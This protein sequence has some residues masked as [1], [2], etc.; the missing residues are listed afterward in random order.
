MLR[1]ALLVLAIAAPSQ[2]AVRGLAVD[3]SGSKVLVA[4]EDRL[5]LWDVA[6]A[7]AARSWALAAH[8]MARSFSGQAAWTRDGRRVVFVGVAPHKEGEDAF[9][10]VEVVDAVTGKIE[11]RVTLPWAP[12]LGRILDVSRDGR[13]AAV[14][15]DFSGDFLLIVDLD[16]G[17]VRSLRGHGYGAYAAD[18]SDDGRL[19][20]VGCRGYIRVWDLAKDESVGA[21]REAREEPVLGVDWFGG[22]RIATASRS[23]ASLWDARSGKRLRRL[24]IGPAN[25]V[26]FFPD[27]ALAVGGDDEVELWREGEPLLKLSAGRRIYA[28]APSADGR[29]LYAGGEGGDVLVWELPEGRLAATW[30]TG[31]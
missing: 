29:R 15:S 6:R 16:S 21:L 14:G 26:V 8:P 2:A 27:G 24:K 23:G 28:L 17:T 13:F 25:A 31:R 12:A 7:T 30:R 19:L 20:A 18:F 22:G 3:P 11:S 9:G 10:A 4:G 5:E 1:A